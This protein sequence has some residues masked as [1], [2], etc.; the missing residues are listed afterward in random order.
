MKDGSS[1]RLLYAPMTA[2][3]QGFL[4]SH[5]PRS[6][7]TT[8][9]MSRSS[10]SRTIKMNQMGKSFPGDWVT[11]D[12]HADTVGFVDTGSTV[13]VALVECKLGPLTLGHLSQLIGYCQV[14]HPAYAFLLS[15]PGPS[16]SLSGLLTVFGRTDI[17]TYGSARQGISRSIVV[18]RWDPV[19]GQID[20]NKT[21]SVGA[22]EHRHRHPV[23]GP[24]NRSVWD[25]C[26]L[27]R[28][29]VLHGL[30]SAREFSSERVHVVRFDASEQQ[31]AAT[32][33]S[34]D[35]ASPF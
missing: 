14:V 13:L 26:A 28:T 23:C 31:P 27:D 25:Q 22:S 18:A 7:V 2:W 6:S 33:R 30:S 8:L 4:V 12:V 29:S 10:L 35:A 1:E 5:H 15:P 16:A 17:L 9:D 11:W 20:R 21:I 32:A 19:A 3:L 34:L 24:R